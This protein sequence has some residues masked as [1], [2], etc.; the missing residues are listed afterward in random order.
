M[1]EL[2]E[3]APNRWR[4]KRPKQPVARSS[5][6]M[7][8]VISDEMPPTEQVNGK[9][10]TSKSAFRRVGR[11]LGLIEVGNEK[12]KPRPRFVDTIGGPRKRRDAIEKAKARYNRGERFY[13]E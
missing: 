8:H 1:I 11:S 7:P 9:F 6:P 13:A 4:V 5:L 10:Y 12:F 3:I 2:I